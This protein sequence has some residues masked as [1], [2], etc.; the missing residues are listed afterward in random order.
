MNMVKT[1]VSREV[2]GDVCEA[3]WQAL[4]G[5]QPDPKN[6]VWHGKWNV[7]MNRTMDDITNKGNVLD[8]VLNELDCYEAD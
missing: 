6:R 5:N 3:A 1:E 8:L 4:A 2:R 7:V